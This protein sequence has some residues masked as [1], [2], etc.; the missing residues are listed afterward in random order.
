LRDDTFR[1]PSDAAACFTRRDRR[2]HA[3][4]IPARGTGPVARRH[5]QLLLAL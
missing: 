4:C 3:P 1:M 5:R 2:R